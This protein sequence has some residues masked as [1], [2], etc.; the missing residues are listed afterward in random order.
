M[1]NR[2][3]TYVARPVPV[4]VSKRASRLQKDAY[5]QVSGGR[6]IRTHDEA[7]TP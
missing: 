2:S 6:G 1:I 4:I 7:Q 3:G 5:Q